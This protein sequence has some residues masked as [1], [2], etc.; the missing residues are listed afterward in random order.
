MINILLDNMY[1]QGL[2]MNLT[3]LPEA[4]FVIPYILNMNN[5]IDMLKTQLKYIETNNINVNILKDRRIIKYN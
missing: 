4:M 1:T 5:V 3:L 2:N